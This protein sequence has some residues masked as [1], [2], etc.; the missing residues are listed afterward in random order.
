[1]D[2]VLVDDWEL[3]GNGSGNPFEIQFST[4]KNLLE[5]YEQFDLPAS[6]NAEVFQ[7]LQHIKWSLKYPELGKI[8]E[9]W[10]SCV[11]RAITHGH[12][13]QLHIHPQWHGALYDGQKWDL[14][15]DWDITKYSKEQ[16]REF[17]RQGRSYLE[18]LIIP[19]KKDY[20]CKT[21]RSGA[22][23]IAPSDFIL[24]VLAD[25][26][27]IFDMSIV[28]GVRYKNDQ[29]SLDYR[30]VEEDTSPYYPLMNDARKVSS[31][32]EAIVEIPTLS[33][34]DPLIP[35]TFRRGIRLMSQKMSWLKKL[36]F[37]TELT[38]RG[39]DGY[40]S[41][42]ASQGG[43]EVW[44]KRD[45]TSINETIRTISD[46]A[47]LTSGQ[48]KRMIIDVRKRIEKKELGRIPV[49]L[50]NHTKDIKTFEPIERFCEWLAKQEDIEVITLTEAAHRLELGRY[51]VQSR[52]FH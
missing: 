5:V 21:Y 31:R 35:Q 51:A 41:G 26:N 46:I 37:I 17:V 40:S 16:A 15:G 12:D 8:S 30:F 49:I 13:V 6:I 9:E 42:Q 28:S 39:V 14:T 3:R 22:W 47:Q 7:Q 25:E 19:L 33:F 10:E 38:Q 23:C 45:G 1:M 34:K 44:N 2:V 20:R 48:M 4:L 43:Y 11:Q 18:N 52:S 24:D 32:K 36:Q 29:I 27:F 50:E